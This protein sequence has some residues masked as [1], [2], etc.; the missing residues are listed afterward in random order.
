[1]IKISARSKRKAYVYYASVALWVII[2][3]TWYHYNYRSVDVTNDSF[4]DI[5]DDNYIEASRPNQKSSNS[6]LSGTSN[7]NNPSSP[8]TATESDSLDEE[9]AKFPDFKKTSTYQALLDDYKIS[10]EIDFHSTV[11]DS[12]FQ[13]HSVESV[14][15]NL[16]FQQRCD[17][18]FKHIFLNDPN[19]RFN[20]DQNYNVVWGEPYSTYTLSHKQEL[21]REYEQQL[22]TKQQGSPQD[23]DPQKQPT[24]IELHMRLQ[25]LQR[26]EHQKE[27][28]LKQQKAQLEHQQ[29]KQNQNQNQNQNQK[30][31]PPSQQEQK[32]NN[33]Q[34]PNNQLNSRQTSYEEDPDFQEFQRQSYIQWKTHEL[35]QKVVDNVSILR[36]YNKCYITNDD[37]K[38][39]Q[40][41]NSFIKK[42]KSLIR[43]ID[44]EVNQV[45]K[46]TPS[47]QERRVSDVE[48]SEVFQR[49]IYPWLSFEMPVFE[50]WTGEISNMPPNYRKILGDN[51]QPVAKPT[52]SNNYNFLRM[53]KGSCQG[54]G[55]VLSIAD[56]HVDYTV[57]LIHS[58]RALNNKLPIQ[59]VYFD[60]LND[61]TK[62]KIVTAAREDFAHL[63]QSYKKIAHLF[64]SDYLDPK[65]KGLPKQEVWFV[66]TASVIN[67]PFKSKFGGFSNKLLAT[68]FNSFN[69]MMIIDA[70][71]VMMQ[72][73]KSYFELEGYKNTGTF[74]FRDR[75]TIENRPMADG[76]F[77]TKVSQSTVDSLMF[78]VPLLTN[79]TLRFDFFR[80]ISHTMESGMVL[81]DR[82]LHFNSILMVVHSNFIN[83]LERL[84]YGDKELY[85]LGFALA[86]DED[87]HFNKHGAAAI[88]QMT[89][90]NDRLRPDGSIHNSKELCS[91]HPGHV[92]EE[93]NHTLLWINSGFRFCHQAPQVDFEKEA[94]LGRRLKFLPQ[95]VEAFKAFYYNPLRIQTAIV[96]PKDPDFRHRNNIQD[97]PNNGWL[98]DYQYC[99]MYL[100]CAYS[101]IGGKVNEE[102]DNTMKGLV[103]EYSAKER[104]MFDY[105][106]DVWIGMD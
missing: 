77:F 11:Y 39:Q 37:S 6:K 1:M 48:F 45:P 76:Q 64:P 55:I 104:A 59:I 20:A 5:Y 25:R 61:E 29:R 100:W 51:S 35:N 73:P 103:I 2:I 106:G 74:F 24:E 99:K 66:N 50:R 9:D 14:L 62:R 65:S 49:R 40:S 33:E 12:I 67:E 80:G 31:N 15:G 93:N 98:M 3:L 28:A 81:I 101:V 22:K 94:S 60:N 38:Q 89:N 63:P 30:Q 10:K 47:S 85:W 4:Y 86:G 92:S 79:Y 42:Q 36:L 46:F 84:S 78:D 72:N 96:P 90:P 87:Y 53:F 58:L 52:K 102:E 43:D 18:F 41:T 95:T 54:K 83:P 32:E 44:D 71:T 16:N 70:D 69:E 82:Q 105:L 26:I 13:Q 56:K 21:I 7:N 34:Q 91:P 88:G 68:F 75:A 57:S 97:E 23:S 19:W 8:N 27:Q 17:L